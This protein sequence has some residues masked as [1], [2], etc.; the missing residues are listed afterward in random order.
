MNNHPQATYLPQASYPIAL[1]AVPNVPSPLVFYPTC[2]L[3]F[4][5]PQPNPLG[6]FSHRSGFVYTPHTLLTT[7][8]FPPRLYIQISI[9]GNVPTSP[10]RPP[11]FGSSIF[12][13]S[14]PDPLFLLLV[15]PFQCSLFL[16]YP[17]FPRLLHSTS[18]LFYPYILYGAVPIHSSSLPR[19]IALFLLPPP[20]VIPSPPPSHRGRPPLPFNSGNIPAFHQTSFQPHLNRYRSFPP[21]QS[22][23]LFRCTFPPQSFL[24]HPLIR[25]CISSHQDT[26]VLSSRFLPYPDTASRPPSHIYLCHPTDD[27]LIFS[28]LPRMPTIDITLRM[29]SHVGPLYPLILEPRPLSSPCPSSPLFRRR[30]FK[31][32][33]SPHRLDLFPSLG[34]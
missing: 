24:P 30:H 20:S 11:A 15:V 34:L 5:L 13:A 28:L 7:Q 22:F 21:R 26:H 8:P 32:L 19:G 4:L 10:P 1:F 17:A 12:P 31:S 18:T 29:S 23:P 14:P 3:P 16:T 6:S 27:S 2:R 33:L 25:P 9:C